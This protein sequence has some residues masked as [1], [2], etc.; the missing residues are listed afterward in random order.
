MHRPAETFFH[1]DAFETEVGGGGVLKI[2]SLLS[3]SVDHFLEKKTTCIKNSNALRMMLNEFK[4]WSDT[5][6]D[7]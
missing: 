7:T 4:M 5:T 2:R 1:S 6:F 3:S